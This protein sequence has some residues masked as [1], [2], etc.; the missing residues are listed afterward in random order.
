[1]N[2]LAR[3]R[4]TF[5]FL[6][7]RATAF[8]DS[9]IAEDTTSVNNFWSTFSDWPME[10]AMFVLASDNSSQKTASF[11]E[12]LVARVKYSRARL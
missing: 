8:E 6:G 12:S 1:M 10:R 2:I 4:L 9:L 11:F 7:E 5:T 3:L